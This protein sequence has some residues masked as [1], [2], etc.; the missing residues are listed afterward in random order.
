MV[1]HN[2]DLATVAASLPPI[3]AFLSANR[4][5]VSDA[6]CPLIPGSL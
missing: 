6:G 5:P 4:A 3:G 2:E 1:V